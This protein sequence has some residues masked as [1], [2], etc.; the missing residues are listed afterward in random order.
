MIPSIGQHDQSASVQNQSENK[1]LENLICNNLMLSN[2]L[3]S[4]KN[5]NVNLYD[6]M[7]GNGITEPFLNQNPMDR[8]NNRNE[9]R[10]S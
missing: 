7:T 9:A 5:N 3:N 6:S 2:W 10:N 4:V 8:F 1:G